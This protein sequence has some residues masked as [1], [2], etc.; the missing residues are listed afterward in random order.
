[1][2]VKKIP[3]VFERD[4][5]GDRSRVLDQVVPGCEW[6]LAGEGV[7]TRK[8]DGT[9]CLIRDGR[10]YKR[11]QVRAG[12]S[13]PEGF[14]IEAAD[15]K[16]DKLIGW[17]PVDRYAPE[18]RW[19]ME[20]AI[21]HLHPLLPPPAVGLPDGTYELL[22]PKVRG[23]P[24]GL[25]SHVLLGHDDAEQLPDAPR[26][27]A[28][29]RAWFEEHDVEGI[30]WHHPDGRMAKLK[31]RDFGVKRP[32]RYDPLGDKVV[33]AEGNEIRVTLTEIPLT[34]LVD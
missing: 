29:F 14:V 30:V 12:K 15:V 5:D 6:V 32:Q 2:A 28:E 27:F 23:N 7:A 31:A 24:E 18:D 20:A 4:W 25:A 19:I 8:Y 1:M 34:R 10:L 9:C 21:E 3:T 16:T 17:V 22:G 11:H 33:D 26:S 13:K